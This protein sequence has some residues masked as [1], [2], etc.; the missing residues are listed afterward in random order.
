MN[1]NSLATL[2]G[3]ALLT[4]LTS[5]CGFAQTVR[6]GQVGTANGDT[7][8]DVGITADP[9]VIFDLGRFRMW[10]THAVMHPDGTG[11]PEI[12][13]SESYDLMTWSKPRLRDFGPGALD[14][15]DSEGIETASVLRDPR[16]GGLLMYYT[17]HRS[18]GGGLYS[19]IG[20]AKSRDN[21]R[22]WIRFPS[23]VLTEQNQWELPVLCDMDGRDYTEPVV[24]GGVLEPSVM[25]FAGKFR[26]WYVGVGELNHMLTFRIGYA[27]SPD[28]MVW[29]RRATPVLDVGEFGDWDDAVVSH[30]NVVRDGDQYR[31]FYFGSSLLTAAYCD[32][33]GGCIQMPGAIGTATSNDGVRW[34]RAPGPVLTNGGNGFDAMTVGGPSAVVANG[35]G[36]ILLWYMG[37][38][39]IRALDMRIGIASWR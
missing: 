1:R 18:C 7:V 13:Y 36:Q 14:T 30:V 21:G 22:T 34:V 32:S 20:L 26:M 16:T 35:N 29:T 15:W 28:G 24:V 25:Y 10:F 17:G 39:N 38:W 27:E 19:A 37:G 2:F 9:S 8:L 11:H 12:G 6:L 33:I 4:V 5:R 3:V 23:P 31:M